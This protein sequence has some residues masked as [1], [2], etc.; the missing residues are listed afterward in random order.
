M[1]STKKSI[2]NIGEHMKNIKS[3]VVKV[4]MPYYPFY[5]INSNTYLFG[6]AHS[7][8]PQTIKN[9][10]LEIMFGCDNLTLEC[11]TDCFDKVNNEIIIN[12]LSRYDDTQSSVIA[13]FDANNNKDNKFSKSFCYFTSAGFVYDDNFL[14]RLKETTYFKSY[15][16]NKNIDIKDIGF[17]IIA[18]EQLHAMLY[19]GIDVYFAN[20]YKLQGKKCY[21][22]DENKLSFVIELFM[23]SFFIIFYVGIFTM[24]LFFGKYIVSSPP[25]NFSCDNDDSFEKMLNIASKRSFLQNHFVIKRNTKW[26]PKI[27]ETIKNSTPEKKSLIIVGAGHI[28]DLIDRLHKKYDVF[29]YD[30]ES[31]E[32]ITF[33]K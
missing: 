31:D 27:E 14:N 24:R 30:Y 2:D 32:F 13:R 7:N 16:K 9:N 25:I 11:N 18:Y 21:Q 3:Y 19:L 22:L 8:N 6:S 5:R 1:D 28:A 26:I 10:I 23:F 29:E 20:F 4:N 17:S 33:S 12:S 15:L